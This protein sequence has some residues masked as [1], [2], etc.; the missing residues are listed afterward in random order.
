[1]VTSPAATFTV[2]LQSVW[3]LPQT[4]CCIISCYVSNMIKTC[5]I[6]LVTSTTPL[7]TLMPTNWDLEGSANLQ[8]VI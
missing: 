1:M 6:Q 3:N 4:C 2:C 7:S 8:A 5:V